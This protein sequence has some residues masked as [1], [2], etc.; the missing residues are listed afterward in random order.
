MS[1][2][3]FSMSNPDGAA[4]LKA[5]W[6]RCVAEHNLGKTMR[7]PVERVPQYRL[8][9]LRARFEGVLV[10]ASSV[11]HRV[12]HLA[13]FVNHVVMVSDKDGVV[14]TSHADTPTSEELSIEGLVAGSVW[15]E[16]IAGTNAIGT[17]LVSARPIA[18]DGADHF[19]DTLKAFMCSS[20]PIVG[21]GGEVVG[22]LDISGRAT[23][24]AADAKFAYHYICAA[25]TE[26]SRILFRRRHRTDCIIALTN[27]P[28]P[29]PFLATALIATD[30]AGAILGATDEALSYLGLRDRRL[31][32]GRNIKDFWNVSFDELKP[33]RGNSV[34]VNVSD[35]V[36]RFATVYLPA[37]KMSGA[38]KGT[39]TREADS[40]RQVSRRI[41]LDQLAGDDP[42]M[43]ENARLCRRIMNRDIPLLVLGD[44]GVGKDTFVRA[45]HSESQ[46]AQG[47]YVAINCAAIPA[48]LLATELFGYAPG[49]FTGGAKGGRIGKI[50]ASNGGYLFLDEIGDMPLELQA[51]LLRVLEERTVT[52]L[53]STEATPVNVRI[54]CATHRNLV[55]MIAKGEFRKDL[56]YRIRGAQ[57]VIPSLKD[58][59][60]LVRLVR[61]IARE[62]CGSREQEIQFDDSVLDVFRHY[63]WPGNIRELRNVIRM[64]FSLNAEQPITTDHLPDYLP[65]FA[66]QSGERAPISA[67]MKNP[68]ANKD[69]ITR[70]LLDA[71][72]TVERQ[73]LV[74]V[75]SS[76]RWNV[77][78][79]A[80]TLGVSRATLH[81]KIR[82]YGIK[83]PNHRF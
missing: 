48:T 56:Y 23:G 35:P 51:H 54:I 22:V 11:I 28:N 16:R 10:D 57:I 60:D 27:E 24:N 62:E 49:T 45:M 71:Q 72:E 76:S 69:H 83:S 65:D 38:S 15:T 61:D 63:P 44:T 59:T 31:L 67:R 6:R 58:R 13:R 70:P 18:V 9:E 43:I 68:H 29:I 47:P 73:R 26:V 36:A 30:E 34:R 42:V 80:L 7:R 37:R 81:R 55:D 74:E 5:S 39:D 8:K 12:R 32:N 2:G 41:S 50:A 82:K 3:T 1:P 19:N 66:R 79:A 33:L 21:A 4:V 25:A 20:A 46:R 40:C 64:I 14:V 52:P 53:G 17:A 75:L 78:D 77:T